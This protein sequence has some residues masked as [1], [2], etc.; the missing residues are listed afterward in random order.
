MGVE[1]K[2]WRFLIFFLKGEMLEMENGLKLRASDFRNE[3]M[4][5]MG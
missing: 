3:K 5:K 4:E 2:C 1:K